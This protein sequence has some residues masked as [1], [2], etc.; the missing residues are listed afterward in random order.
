MH[1]S[2]WNPYET[3]TVDEYRQ[4]VVEIHLKL[5]RMCARL[6]DM[7]GPILLHKNIRPHVTYLTQLR[8]NEMGYKTL[9]NSEHSPDLS[10][11]DYHFFKPLDDFLCTNCFKYE[12]DTNN[13]FNVF[14]AFKE[15][16][17][18]SKGVIKLV[19]R[20]DKFV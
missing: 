1:C 13:V 9:L 4:Q 14:M 16:A 17:F 5:R 6:V 12:E 7:K 11:A 19:S 20:W 2:F 18:Y 15:K 10:A 8:L 3:K